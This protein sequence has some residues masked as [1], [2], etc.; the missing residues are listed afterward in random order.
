MLDINR[1]WTVSCGQ[2]CVGDMQESVAGPELACLGRIRGSLW[3]GMLDLE[4]CLDIRQCLV[5][6]SQL[7]PR[8]SVN[9]G[10]REV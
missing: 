10:E 5:S 3:I 6:G 9:S 8:Y 4:F 2:R 7:K 1:E